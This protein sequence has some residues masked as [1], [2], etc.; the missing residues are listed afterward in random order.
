MVQ[1]LA[2]QALRA[3]HGSCCVALEVGEERPGAGREFLGPGG[4]KGENDRDELDPVVGVSRDVLEFSQPVA[5]SPGFG[6]EALHELEAVPEVLRGDAKGVEPFG[7]RN[8]PLDEGI[9]HLPNAVIDELPQACLDVA[10]ISS[11]DVLVQKEPQF[12]QPFREAPVEPLFRA[13]HGPR[14]LG[15]LQE[16]GVE[17]FRRDPLG[18]TLLFGVS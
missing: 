1:K 2:G 7:R 11:L 4:G 17:D 10:V 3:P 12:G 15:V 9:R 5:Q 14:F 6:H 8:P 18:Q 13:L 16:T